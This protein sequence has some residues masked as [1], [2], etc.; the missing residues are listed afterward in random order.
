MEQS[1]SFNCWINNPDRTHIYRAGSP[2]KVIKLVFTKG[3]ASALVLWRGGAIQACN[4]AA[5]SAVSVE[6]H[7]H[8][9][10]PAGWQL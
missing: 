6:A 5:Q 8:Q 4:L 3:L 1:I 9:N 10:S 2:A 7:L